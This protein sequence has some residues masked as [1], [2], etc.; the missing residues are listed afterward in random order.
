MQE[1]SAVHLPDPVA[2][3]RSGIARALTFSR[4]SITTRHPAASLTAFGALQRGTPAELPG[5][6]P[7]QSLEFGAT[8][9]FFFAL[10]RM[11]RLPLS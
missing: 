11:K 5:E 4:A 7:I 9:R 2:I 3:S 8:L 6:M 1:S 10:T